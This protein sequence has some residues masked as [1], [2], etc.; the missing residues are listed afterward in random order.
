MY[1]ATH[2]TSEPLKWPISPHNPLST[3]D[4]PLKLELCFFEDTGKCF[5]EHMQERVLWVRPISTSPKSQQCVVRTCVSSELIG[6]SYILEKFSLFFPSEFGCTLKHSTAARA[7]L[8]EHWKQ[9][10]FSRHLM[11]SSCQFMLTIKFFLVCFR[12]MVVCLHR[13][14]IDFCCSCLNMTLL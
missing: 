3:S 5:C 10:S 7:L 2:R 4:Q 13:T 8:T 11:L 1:E 9:N 12:V 14:E 6:W